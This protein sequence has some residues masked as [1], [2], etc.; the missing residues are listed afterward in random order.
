MKT[1]FK[2]DEQ[3]KLKDYSQNTPE[4]GSFFD[5]WFSNKKGKI[6][7]AGCGVGNYVIVFSKA[8]FGVTGIELDKKRAELAKKNAQKYSVSAKII[9]RDIRKLPFKADSFDFIFSHWVVEHF[10]ETQKGVNE[11]YKVLKRNGYTMISV[12]AR[13]SSFLLFKYVQVFIDKI[14]KIGLWNCGYEKS[15][16]LWRFRKLLKKA[17]FKLIEEKISQAVPGKRFPIM[18]TIERVLDKPFYWLGIGGRFMH[19]WCEK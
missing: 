5:N 13:L 11:L 17:G 19:F 9:C 3:F 14:F 15:F 8:G 6:L 7:E 10:P 18:G 16:T 4:K 2:G 1:S 12:P